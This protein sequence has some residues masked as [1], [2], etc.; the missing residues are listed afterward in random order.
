MMY[1]TTCPGN[2]DQGLRTKLVC[3]V[4]IYL[5]WCLYLPCG[6]DVEVRSRVLK[7]HWAVWK[8]L[9]EVG[10][11]VLHGAVRINEGVLL[12]DGNQRQ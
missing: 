6:G 11:V 4:S 7:V 5:A 1:L 10:H 2:L 3:G 12:F 9:L 8:E